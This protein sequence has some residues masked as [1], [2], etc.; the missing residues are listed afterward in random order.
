MGTSLFAH[1]CGA[2]EQAQTMKERLM[3]GMTDT[4][5][6]NPLCWPIWFP[7]F[8]SSHVEAEA[9]NIEARTQ[10]RLLEQRAKTQFD[11]I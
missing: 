9:N 7:I 4:D 5:M 1:G 2:W 11:I 3:T 6:L 10:N 8:H